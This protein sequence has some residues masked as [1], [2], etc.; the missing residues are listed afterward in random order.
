MGTDPLGCT[1]PIQ[2]IHYAV[3][4]HLIAVRDEKGVG[5]ALGFRVGLCADGF[6]VRERLR[7]QFHEGFVLMG[8]PENDAAFRVEGGFDADESGTLVEAAVAFLDERIGTVVH[9]EK[10]RVET[11]GTAPIDD[12]VNIPHEDF[13]AR[14]VK[15]PAVHMGKMFPVPFHNLGHELGD[16]HTRIRAGQLEDAFQ[17][18]AETET[19]DQDVRV[20]R[21]DR[22]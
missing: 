7:E 13:H 4:N 15:K 3:A 22:A 2:G 19:A 20:L 18:E 10:D 5:E 11:I 9:I 12:V 1:S 14:I 6:D 16:N 8:G 21:Q 17:G